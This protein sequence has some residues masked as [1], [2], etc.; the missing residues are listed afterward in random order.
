MNRRDAILQHLCP[1]VMVPRF[2]AVAPMETIG[3]RYL[4]AQD[5]LY[6]DLQTP[7]LSLTVKT[8]T[9]RTALPYGPVIEQLKLKFGNSLRSAL[10]RFEREARTAAPIEH[11]AWLSFDGSD[12]SLH[13]ESV[14]VLDASTD[15]IRYE[16]P[17]LPALR[18][19]AVDIHSHGHYAA[20][21][22][23]ED[24]RDSLDDAKLE[25]VFGNLDR[26]TPSVACRLSALG[27]HLD[28]SKWLSAF[29]Y[30]GG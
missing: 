8:A 29:L 7:W 16:R 21:F 12:Q 4:M 26:A 19:L 14:Q 10:R 9:N 23:D 25:V 13:Y 20:G 28:Y 1:T 6:L 3:H 11:A 24:D 22:S 15:L 30:A 17:E 2:E 5:G 18:V 27:L